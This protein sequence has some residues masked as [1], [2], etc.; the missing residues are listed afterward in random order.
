MNLPNY[1]DY[2]LN[3]LRECERNID[4]IRFSHRYD[5]ITKEIALRKVAGE[6]ESEPSFEEFFATGVP[7]WVGIGAWWRFF[8][9]ST[10]V[11]GI[12]AVLFYTSADYLWNGVGFSPWMLS[13]VKIVFMVVI[14]PVIGIAVMMQTLAKKYYGYRIYIREVDEETKADEGCPARTP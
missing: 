4:R 8:W 6:I 5:M 7:L 11:T 3:Q 14:V 1:T 10:L 12:L 9:R 13:V 2:T